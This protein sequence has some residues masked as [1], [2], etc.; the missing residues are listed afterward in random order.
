MCYLA[1]SRRIISCCT[2]YASCIR[3]Q[4]PI[5]S[6]YMVGLS[7]TST[8]AVFQYLQTCSRPPQELHVQ[9]TL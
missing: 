6:L 5:K 1:V 9:A 2:S 8:I 7:Q 3:T 4:A